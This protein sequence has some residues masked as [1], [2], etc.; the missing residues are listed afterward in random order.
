MDGAFVDG[1][2]AFSGEHVGAHLDHT[3]R[4]PLDVQ[5]AVT[6]TGTEAG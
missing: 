1:G 5:D 2:K 4:R 6:V 3:L